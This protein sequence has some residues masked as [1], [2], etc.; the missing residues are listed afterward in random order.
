VNSTIGIYKVGLN[1]PLKKIGYYM[2]D[3]SLKIDKQNSKKEKDNEKSVKEQ[4]KM[5]VVSI[6]VYRYNLQQ[7][8][9]IVIVLMF[10]IWG[11]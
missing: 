6:R 7:L 4:R 10:K 2:P 9:F 5:R 11:I 3:R 8:Y 1:Q